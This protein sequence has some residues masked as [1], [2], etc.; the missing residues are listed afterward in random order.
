MKS[1]ALQEATASEPLTLEQ[2][3]A[4]QTSWRDDNDKCTF[5]LLSTTGSSN[6]DTLSCSSA[7]SNDGWPRNAPM[8]GDVNLFLN[9]MDDPHCAE[10]E[11]MIAEPDYRRH[12]AATEALQMMM[13]Y[14]STV[15]G[16]RK[17]VAKIG[18]KNT[19]SIHLFTNKLHFE[20]VSVSQVFEEITFA[21]TID[22]TVQSTLNETWQHVGTFSYDE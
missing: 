9:D 11:I 6:G 2:E 7:I 13:H 5:I 16:L 14:G 12:G 18:M 20:Q 15:L 3:Y 8:I 22:D 4:M 17:F 10:I 19:G 21:L 1:P